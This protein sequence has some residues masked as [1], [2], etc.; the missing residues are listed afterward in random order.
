MIPKMVART[1]DSAEA[2]M[3]MHLLLDPLGTVFT[4]ESLQVFNPAARVAIHGGNWRQGQQRLPSA[5][6][7]PGENTTAKL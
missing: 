7:V 5:A 4:S 1:G 2:L 3:V 6:V